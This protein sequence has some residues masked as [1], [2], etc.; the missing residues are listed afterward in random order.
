[1]ARIGGTTAEKPALVIVDPVRGS[2]W[3]TT[4]LRQ[5]ILE[6]RYAHGEKLPA[7]RQFA[8]AFGASRATIRS[9]LIRPETELPPT[10]RLA[11][12]TPA[13]YENPR[14]PHAAAQPPIP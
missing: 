9:A 14:P 2:A 5:A 8:S 12:G 13:N 10:R 4:Q 1:M 11:A 3:I 7:E 6:G